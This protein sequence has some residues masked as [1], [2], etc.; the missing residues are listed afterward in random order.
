[1]KK[2]KYLSILAVAALFASCVKQGPAG[3]QG[4]NGLNGT[5]NIVAY[6]D[7]IP[8]ADWTYSVS[9]SQWYF[10]T[11]QVISNGDGIMVYESS[12]SNVYEG[13]P[14]SNTFF[15]GDNLNFKYGNG[16]AVSIWYT[17]TSSPITKPN[18]KIMIEIVD[19]P[20]SMQVKYPKVNWSNQSEVA[21][22]PEYKAA[23]ANTK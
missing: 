16:A 2:I 22:L 18:T 17:N 14:A 15:S 6:Y 8:V 3:P 12:G 13:L 21:Q 9:A 23:L 19:I 10:N 20:P 7:S 11:T 4:E 1:M 5:S